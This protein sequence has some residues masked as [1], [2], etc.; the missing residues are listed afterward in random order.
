MLK[1]VVVL[2]ALCSVAGIVGN[3]EGFAAGSVQIGSV[4]LEHPS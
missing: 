4:R 3:G 2:L 1:R